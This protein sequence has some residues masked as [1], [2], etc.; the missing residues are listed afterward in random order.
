MSGT[1][2]AWAGVAVAALTLALAVVSAM[3]RAALRITAED[4]TQRAQIIQLGKDMAE[5]VSDSERARS[6]ILTQL[7]N[8]RAATDRRLRWLEEHVWRSSSPTR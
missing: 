3:L 6:E 4:A 2:A 8:D 7:T 5:L 1:E